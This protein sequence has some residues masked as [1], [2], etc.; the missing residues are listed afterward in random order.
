MK[1]QEKHQRF[2]EMDWDE[3]VGDICVVSLAFSPVPFPFPEGCEKTL[4]VNQ[5]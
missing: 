2:G 1:L 4:R 3:K 5:K